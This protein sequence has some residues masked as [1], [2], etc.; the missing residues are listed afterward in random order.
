MNRIITISREFGSGGR[1][2][3]KR[4]SEAMGIAYYDRE[5][6]TAIAEKSHLAQSYVQS[7]SEKGTYVYPIHYGRTFSF[8]PVNQD[9]QTKVLVAQQQI[10]QELAETS[11]C[12]IVGRCADVILHDYHPLNLFV[13]ADMASKL[14]RCR[15]KAFCDEALSEKAMEKK[16]R[17]VDAGRAHYRQLLADSKWDAKENY[18][19]CINTSGTVI[20]NL[21]PPILSYA[22]CWFGEALQ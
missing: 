6:I 11:D 3:G 8:R 2:L 16:I 5:I 19:L 20:K 14:I 13:Y 10:L 9:N 15:E 21:I 4:L 1:E 12:V 17:Q 22:N 18:Q 7:I